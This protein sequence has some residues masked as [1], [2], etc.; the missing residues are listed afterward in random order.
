MKNQS[1]I[2]VIVPV[3]NAERFLTE[4]IESVLKQS[5]KS[6]ELLLIDDGSED[7]SLS[8]CKEYEEKDDRIRVFSNINHGVSYTRN[9][10]IKESKGDF[11]CFLDSDDILAR[12][13]LDTLV[14][15]MFECDNID[16]NF[17]GYNLLYDDKVIQRQNRI[18]SGVYDYDDL[19]NILIDDGTLSGILFGSVCGT[20]YRKEV[21]NKYQI[22]FDE[23]IKKNEDG[24]FNL[25]LLPHIQNMKVS[26]Y[27]GYLYRQWKASSNKAKTFNISNELDKAT[28][29]IS[30]RCGEYVDF[31]EQIRRRNVS[32]V[33]WNL[34]SVEECTE[35]ISEVVKKI[36]NYI[37]NTS[38]FDDYKAL[39][40]SELSLY[41][42]TLVRIL[43]AKQY[44][45][46][47]FLIRYIKPILEKRFNH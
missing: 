46:F 4:C 30:K 7:N 24:L 23:N 38:F 27:K 13:F 26:S 14:L 12:D 1:L 6:L 43:Y 42:K 33:F 9:Y 31:D 36:K 34:L 16:V 32:V 21:I 8:I 22:F 28:V 10:G 20:L 5:Y 29:A 35:S 37:S 18:E 3:Y 44:R 45:M 19:S 25:E 39:N 17:S 2:S 40:F 41:K 15:E 11:I 47:A